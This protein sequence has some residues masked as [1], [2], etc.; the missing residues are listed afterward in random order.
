MYRVIYGAFEEESNTFSP[1]VCTL[2]QFKAI[3][4]LEGEAI[5]P[6]MRH[7]KDSASGILETLEASDVEVIPSMA[8]SL[9]HI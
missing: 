5:L 2:D 8:L 6:Y 4:C 9:I 1:V 3:C 7:K